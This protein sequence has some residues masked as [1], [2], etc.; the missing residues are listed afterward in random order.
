MKI[1]KLEKQGCAPCKMVQGYLEAN[2]GDV[3]VE[4]V[5]AFENPD[6]AAKY[7]I[8]SVPVTI[9]LDSTGDEVSRSIGFNPDELDELIDL[10]SK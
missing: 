7:E 9:L 8:S 4:V 10:A 3:E 1:L 2:A 6:V 5:D